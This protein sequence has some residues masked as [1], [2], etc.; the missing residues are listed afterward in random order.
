MVISTSSWVCQQTFGIAIP[1]QACWI[2]HNGHKFLQLLGLGFFNYRQ[3]VQQY[4]L[5]SQKVFGTSGI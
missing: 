5:K 2:F 4:T 3:D 1:K